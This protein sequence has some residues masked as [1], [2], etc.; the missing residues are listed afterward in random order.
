MWQIR[1]CFSDIKLDGGNSS[2]FSWDRGKDEFL[3]RG[4]MGL[5]DLKWLDDLTKF[6][7]K[8]SASYI[9]EMVSLK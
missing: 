2:I 4:Q 5:V 1:V 6:L 7:S 3:M 9:S 8:W